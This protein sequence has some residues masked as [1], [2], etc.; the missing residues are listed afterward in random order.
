MTDQPDSDAGWLGA[1]TYAEHICDEECQRTDHGQ[2]TVGGRELCITTSSLIAAMRRHA[3]IVAT[4]QTHELR[5]AAADAQAEARRLRGVLSGLR[6]DLMEITEST[7]SAA[8]DAAATIDR[9]VQT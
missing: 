1:F 3:A 8:N 5:C 9:A 7:A 4:A 6:A 2:I